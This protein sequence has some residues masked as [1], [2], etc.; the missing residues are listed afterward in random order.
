MPGCCEH[1]IQIALKRRFRPQILDCVAALDN[2][3][4][5]I[6]ET[7][8]KHFRRSIALPRKQ[9]ARRLEN[10]NQPLKTLQERIVQIAGDSRPLLRLRCELA[11]DVMQAQSV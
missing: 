9:I 3:L 6:V 11:P 2:G 1:R 7:F 10:G 8:V 5:R 4:R